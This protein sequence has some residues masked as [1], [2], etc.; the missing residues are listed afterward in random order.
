VGLSESMQSTLASPQLILYWPQF[1][2]LYTGSAEKRLLLGTAEN[3]MGYIVLTQPGLV[4]RAQLMLVMLSQVVLVSILLEEW[5]RSEVK[6]I[7]ILKN[8][9]Q[10]PFPRGPMR[11]INVEFKEA[12]V[13]VA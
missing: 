10:K 6:F 13:G 7:K 1:P 9:A 8:I 3:T 5:N 11:G 2:Y 12:G 4:V